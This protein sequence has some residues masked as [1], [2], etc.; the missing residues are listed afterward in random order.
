LPPFIVTEQQVDDFLARFR[1]LLA[2]TKLPPPY[3]PEPSQPV[4]SHALAGAR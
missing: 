3:L 2:Q 1:K 4:P